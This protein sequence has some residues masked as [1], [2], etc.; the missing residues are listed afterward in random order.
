MIRRPPRSTLF[1][2]TTLFRSAHI[3]PQAGGDPQRADQRHHPARA[4]GADRDR[5]GA[6]ADR[7]ARGRGAGGRLEEDTSEIP[8]SQYFAWRPLLD[9]KK[10]KNYGSTYTCSS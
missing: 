5:G 6:A 8:A 2:Y 1:P 4:G 10:N 9:K 3:R 7:T